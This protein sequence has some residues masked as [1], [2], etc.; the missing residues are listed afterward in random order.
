MSPQD[1][2]FW[3]AV[4]R[5]MVH[6]FIRDRPHTL[7]FLC[8][9]LAHDAATIETWDTCTKVCNDAARAALAQYDHLFACS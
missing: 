1:T 8:R 4:G 9:S 5:E 7:T 3:Q 6:E 2:A